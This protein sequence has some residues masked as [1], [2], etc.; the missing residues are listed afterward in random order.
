VYFTV[1]SIGAAYIVR[2]MGRLPTGEELE[3]PHIPQ[4]AAGITPASAI[5]LP[6]AGVP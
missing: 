5:V 4:H 1:F 6:P 2:M 3:P